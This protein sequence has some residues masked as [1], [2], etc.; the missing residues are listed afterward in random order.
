LIAGFGTEPDQGCASTICLSALTDSLTGAVKAS[1]AR[2][3]VLGGH[4]SFGMGPCGTIA[5][6][7]HRLTDLLTLRLGLSVGGCD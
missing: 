2:A 7:C 6:L 5:I 3:Y 1:L 4:G